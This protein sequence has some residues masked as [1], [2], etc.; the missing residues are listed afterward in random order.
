MMAAHLHHRIPR[1]LLRS[2][3]RAC[4]GE[5]DGEGLQ[6]WFDWEEEAFRFGVDPDVS[7]VD[8]AGL[9]EASAAHIPAAEH[10]RHH[11]KAGDFS[12]WGRQGGLATLALYGRPWFSLLGRRRWGRIGAEVLAHHRAERSAE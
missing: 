12:R 4:K 3:D 7:R 11:S 1:C 10:R 6:A 8:L 5:L 2:Y 9:I